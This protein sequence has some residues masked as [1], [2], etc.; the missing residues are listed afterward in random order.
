MGDRPARRLKHHTRAHT[1]SAG[2]LS[3]RASARADVRDM[4]LAVAQAQQDLVLAMGTWK[5]TSPPLAVD[6]PHVGAYRTEY[7]TVFGNRAPPRA[8][9]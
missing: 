5:D 6:R 7:E 2:T 8:F 1:N 4:Q 9:G 3:A